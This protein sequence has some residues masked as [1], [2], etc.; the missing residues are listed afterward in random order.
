[1]R[2]KRARKGGGRVREEGKRRDRKIKFNAL[3]GH[4]IIISTK[5]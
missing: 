2:E 3:A 4:Q 1:M 5:R